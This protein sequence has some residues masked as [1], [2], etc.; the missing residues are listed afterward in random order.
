MKSW[1][2]ATP[3]EILEARV[4]SLEE[5]LEQLKE[6]L[7]WALEQTA[8]RDGSPVRPEDVLNEEWGK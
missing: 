1:D 7:M 8:Q 4:Q 2:N 5:G 6:I 3:I